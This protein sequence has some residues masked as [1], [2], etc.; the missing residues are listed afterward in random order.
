MKRN[1]VDR[2]NKEGNNKIRAESHELENKKK[3]LKN[4]TKPKPKR[5]IRSVAQ[6]IK[7]KN[8]GGKEQNK[9]GSEGGSEREDVNKQSTQ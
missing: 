6:L 8:K 9:R 7:E 5:L 3:Q 4:L 2:N 1:R